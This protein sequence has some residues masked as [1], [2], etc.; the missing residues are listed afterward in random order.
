MLKNIMRASVALAALA[1]PLA[2][3]D[4]PTRDTV[5]ATVNGTEITLGEVILTIAQL[6]AQ[7]QGAPAEFLFENVLN[8]LIQQQLLA[9][10][11]ETSP[12]R[13]AIAL[14]NQERALLAGEA[15]N[16]FLP[17][18][19]SEEAIRA[20]YEENFSAENAATEYSAAHILVATEDEAKAIIER[21]DAGEAFADLAV[22]LSQDP[23]SGANGGD[24]GWFVPE[25]MVAPF[26]DTVAGMEDGAVSEPIQTQFGWHVILRNEARKQEAPAF[27]Q[28]APELQAQLENDAIEARLE[29]LNAAATIERA[30]VTG[31]D[32]AI[33][34][35]ISLLA[36]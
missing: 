18:S 36:N 5:V 25:M 14:A 31:F 6:P 16:I 35:D 23:G 9:D 2:A 34:G 21:I 19:V 13:V 24:L 12:A 32:P 10:T 8:Q 1:S 17:E 11:V 29:E 15:I 26:G 7:Y 3:Q 20:A 30:D 22:E 33:F 28:V 27:E 4:A